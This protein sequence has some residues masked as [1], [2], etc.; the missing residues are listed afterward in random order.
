MQTI[1]LGVGLA[2]LCAAAI[3][4]GNRILATLAPTAFIRLEPAIAGESLRVRGITD[5]PDGAEIVYSIDVGSSPDEGFG[6]PYVDD[7]V[8][9]SS[10]AFD[11][12]VDIARFPSGPLTVWA[13]F[14]P[15]GHQPQE[16]IERFGVDGS[17]L[18]GPGVVD[19]YGRRLIAIAVVDNP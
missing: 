17:G 5:L 1:G 14:D 12:A 11:E 4:V 16:V 13:A 6:G 2:V 19:D 10:G 9:V 7:A 8:T 3:T 15:G 18:R